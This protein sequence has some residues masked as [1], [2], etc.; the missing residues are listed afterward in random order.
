M[1]GAPGAGKG[2]VGK[3]LA[4]QLGIT[5]LSSGDV[6]RALTKDETELGKKIKKCITKL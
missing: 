6:F 5:H 3:R 1:L 2:T 4:V